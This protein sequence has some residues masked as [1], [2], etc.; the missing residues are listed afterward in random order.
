MIKFQPNMPRNFLFLIDLELFWKIQ[1][2]LKETFV[3]DNVITLEEKLR[4]RWCQLSLK[5]DVINIK[6]KLRGW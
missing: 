4:E 6:G 2:L 3:G 1:E 5:N